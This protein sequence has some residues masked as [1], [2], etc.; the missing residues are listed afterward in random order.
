MC[1]PA[2]RS[3]SPATLAALVE[4]YQRDR[5]A[6][7]DQVLVGFYG[8]APPSE[9]LLDA[10]GGLPFQIRVRP[11]LLS[12]ADVARLLER[13]LRGVELDVL[14]FDDLVLRACRRPYRKHRVLQMATGL[15]EAGLRVGVT[16]APGLPG[17]GFETSIADAQL[18]AVHFDTARIHPVLVLDRSA[19]REVHAAGQYTPLALGEA[20]TV[21]RAMMDVLEDA[22]V[23]VIRV[24]MQPGPDGLGRAIAGPA[25]SSL[26]ELVEARRVLDRLY[27]LVSPHR[28]VAHVRVNCAPADVGRT[29]GPYNQHKR[30][31]R[32][33]FGIEQI[34]IRADPGLVR[35]HWTVEIL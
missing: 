1:N 7:G 23:I 24:G 33:E 17:S 2:P 29:H 4:H 5:A 16:L 10:I 27:T 9:A 35:N 20:V 32:A 26:R 15:R 28:G 12:R 3:P 14:C 31:L 13:G 11:D 30:A 22:G 18:A 19:L 34:E 21:C 8:G 25:H 6:P